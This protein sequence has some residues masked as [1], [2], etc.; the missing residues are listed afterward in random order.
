MFKW[1]TELSKNSTQSLIK[2]KSKVLIPVTSSVTSVTVTK[3]G[4]GI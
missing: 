4:F 3:F 2:S 1:F